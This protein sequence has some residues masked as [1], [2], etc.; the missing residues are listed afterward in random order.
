[1]DEDVTLLECPNCEYVSKVYHLD[2]Y[3]IVCKGCDE[4]ITLESYLDWKEQA[5][6]NAM[7]SQSNSN[8][9]WGDAEDDNK[10]GAK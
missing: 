4:E 9:I 6:A 5:Y 1:M 10:G 2:W 8:T 7:E 3:A